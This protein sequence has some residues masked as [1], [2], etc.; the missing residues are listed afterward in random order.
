MTF[1]TKILFGLI[2]ICILLLIT[3]IRVKPE[4]KENNS[5]EKIKNIVT[6]I[7]LLHIWFQKIGAYLGKN[8][9]TFTSSEIKTID[10]LTEQIIQDVE[11]GFRKILLCLNKDLSPDENWL[12]NFEAWI[13]TANDDEFE[14]KSSGRDVRKLL[15]LI[16]VLLMWS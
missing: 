7:E 16:I 3:R 4:E 6:E 13:K 11:T 1:P 15:L 12:K 8:R 2:T 10:E 9:H 5:I 14:E